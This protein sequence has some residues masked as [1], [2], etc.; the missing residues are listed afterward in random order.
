[1]VSKCVLFVMLTVFWSQSILNGADFKIGVERHKAS[2][3]SKNSK[4]GTIFVAPQ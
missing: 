2:D 3:Y 4:S 1:M